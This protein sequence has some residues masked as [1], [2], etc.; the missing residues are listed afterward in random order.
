MTRADFD[1]ALFRCVQNG[2]LPAFETLFK[3]YYKKLCHF[4]HSFVRNEQDAEEIVSD[5]FFKIWKN[6]DTLKI[7]I[8]FSAYVYKA[9]Q[10]ACLAKLK[11]RHPL[12]EDIEDLVEEDLVY[13]CEES[14]PLEA[15]N[16]NLQHYQRALNALPPRCK[17]IFVMNRLDGMKY[18]EIADH[19][20]I[21]IKTVEHQLV[22]ALRLIR[23]SVSK[24]K[25]ETRNKTVTIT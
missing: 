15:S 18:R 5:L 24:Y 4:A 14:E 16:D 25:T 3:R 7:D 13:E 10:H 20:D 19:L 21:S 22:K 11:Q 17:L 12:F 9:C 2:D 8:S 23:F 6:R 1:I